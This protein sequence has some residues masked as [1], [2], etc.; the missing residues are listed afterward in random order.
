MIVADSYN[1][2]NF[3]YEPER[4]YQEALE[5]VPDDWEVLLKLRRYYERMNDAA[6]AARVNQALSQ[7]LTP[8]AVVP[9]D[10][11]IGKEQTRTLP[12][13]LDS[14]SI[15]LTLSFEPPEGQNRPLISVL[16]NG[17]VIWEDTL[18]SAELALKVEATPGL[19]RLEIIPVNG[20]VRLLGWKWER[21]V[22]EAE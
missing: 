20:P 21:V 15:I 2:L 3:V 12:F 9:A 5:A 8:P 14:S 13:I 11:L 6:K 1:K 17:R 22:P 7:A 10:S 18:A 19:N 16:F 4:F